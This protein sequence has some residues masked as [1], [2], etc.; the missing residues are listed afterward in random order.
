MKKLVLFLVVGMMFLPAVFGFGLASDF[1]PNGTLELSPNAEYDYYINI[2][3]GQSGP[4]FVN[5]SVTSDNN[6]ARI[7]SSSTVFEIPERTYDMNIPLHISIPWN[8]P[9]GKTFAVSYVAQPVAS[10]GGLSFT[11]VLSRGFI[12]KVSRN[13]FI[14]R[15]VLPQQKS[16]SEVTSNAVK[17]INDNKFEI[18]GLILAILAVGLLIALVWKRSGFISDKIF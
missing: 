13:G 5:I 2:Q 4:I 1:L 11:V 17:K 9:E 8:A 3:N 6:I 16:L 14:A 15:G 7:N 12:V 18:G 10:Q